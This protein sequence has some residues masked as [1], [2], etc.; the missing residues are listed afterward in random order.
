MGAH[1]AAGREDGTQQTK[2]EA[3]QQEHGAHF[4]PVKLFALEYGTGTGTST[5][6]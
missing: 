1:F 4:L 5:T 6:D 2:R 3:K